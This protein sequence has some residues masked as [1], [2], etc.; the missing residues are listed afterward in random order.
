[1]DTHSNLPGMLRGRRIAIFLGNGGVGKTTV[2]ATMAVLSALEGRHVLA[3]TVDPSN[4]LKTALGLTGRPGIEE[5]VSLAAFSDKPT[6]TLHAMILDAATELDR[7]VHRCIPSDEARRRITQNVFYREAASKLAGTHEYLA[8]ERVLECVECG[9]YDLVILDTP[10]DRHALDFLDAP[11]RLQDLLSSDAFRIFVA[12]SKGVS[13]V[14]IRA[15]RFQSLMLRG[16]GRFAGEEAFLSVLDF[17][18]S[19][20]P[21]FEDFRERAGRVRALLGSDAC[22]T[23]LVCRPERGTASDV[24]SSIAALS[25]RG[26]RVSAVVANNV[27]IWPPPPCPCVPHDETAYPL[28][29]AAMKDALLSDPSLSLVDP[30]SLRVLAGRVLTLAADYRNQAAEDDGHVRR[31]W[32]TIAPTPIFPL[33]QLVEEICDPAGLARF[34]SVMTRRTALA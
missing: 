32:E 15:V 33:P 27:R 17:L 13:R 7:L 1:M 26:V 16:L 6:G 24:Q 21:L 18:L 4:R 20:S 5:S 11:G 2:A 23:F 14:G 10:P 19:L 28:D 31:L 9:Q 3:L 8:M 30:A 25:E 12:A 29:A 34:A 22:G